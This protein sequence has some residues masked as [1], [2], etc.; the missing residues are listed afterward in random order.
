MNSTLDLAF[1]GGIPRI[2]GQL[3][4]RRRHDTHKEQAYT[5]RKHFFLRSRLRLR[6]TRGAKKRYAKNRPGG[7]LIAPDAGDADQ[8][9]VVC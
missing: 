2:G 5:S 8:T 4:R 6:R 9:Q 3:R 1:N 7:F